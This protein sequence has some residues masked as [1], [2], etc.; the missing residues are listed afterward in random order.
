M[1]L[2]SKSAFLATNPIAN[3]DT[4]SRIN[5]KHVDP[6]TK[7][8][9]GPNMNY[10]NLAQVTLQINDTNVPIRSLVGVT[11]GFMRPPRNLTC[12]PDCFLFEGLQIIKLSP[13]CMREDSA[14]IRAGR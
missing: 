5:S 9:G 14:P 12:H 11:V 7:I 2:Q 4:A 13:L 10:W 1:I 8:T 6:I 3:S